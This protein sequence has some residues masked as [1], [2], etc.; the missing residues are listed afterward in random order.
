M[1]RSLRSLL[2]RGVVCFARFFFG[3]LVYFTRSARFFL[4]V[5]FARF[6][7]RYVYVSLAPLA[8]FSGVWCVSLA[9][10]RVSGVFRSLRALVFK[11]CGVFR[12][13]RSL[14]FLVC[15]VFRSLLFGCVVCFRS[16]HSLLF[17][18]FACV[19]ISLAPVSS[20]C[21]ARSTR[22]E[23]NSWFCWPPLTVAPV[24]LSLPV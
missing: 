1:F 4:A 8:S 7:S 14:L 17:K 24:S 3:C 18:V 15:G 23:R 16:L 11:V 19:Y 10:F 5:C 6:F 22:P 20:V 12:S 21:C 9:S 13:L 2:S